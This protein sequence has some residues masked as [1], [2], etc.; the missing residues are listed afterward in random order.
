MDEGFQELLNPKALR[1]EKL[2]LDVI[3]YR[4]GMKEVWDQL[5][6]VVET[7]SERNVVDLIADDVDK[8]LEESDFVP[9]QGENHDPNNLMLQPLMKNQLTT[10]N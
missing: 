9:S 8:V 7:L 1:A 4:N 3:H 2:F 5:I 6:H 10:E